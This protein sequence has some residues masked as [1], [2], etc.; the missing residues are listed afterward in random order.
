MNDLQV[1]FKSNALIKA[2]Y[3]FT[4]SQNRVL[5]K[6][7]YEIQKNKI[8]VAKITLQELKSL[9]KFKD[10]STVEGIKRFL[11]NLKENE[12]MHIKDNGE[13]LK[14]Q[15][16]SGYKYNPTT[17]IFKIEIPML[18]LQLIHE[19]TQT[20]FTPTNVTKYIGLGATNAQ[21]LY[22]LLRMWTG[23]KTIIEYSVDEIKEYLMLQ[24]KYKVFNNFRVRVIESAVKE[25]RE[26]ELLDIYNVEYVKTGR[27]VTS[28]KFYVKDLEPRTYKFETKKDFDK[29]KKEVSGFAN[30]TQRKYNYDKLEKQ[31]LGWADDEEDYEER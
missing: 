16:I 26:K 27:K 9:I 15:V 11:E 24:N 7:F 6:A 3:D 25:L 14:V 10:Y 12:I 18:L 21:R 29:P 2:K 28:I 17:K 20:G 13:W 1:L 5:Q 19:Y 4:V 22:E 8:N 31:L 23:N 30:F